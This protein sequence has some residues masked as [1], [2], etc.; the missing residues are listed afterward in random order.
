MRILN[1]WSRQPEV[2]PVAL[3]NPRRSGVRKTGAPSSQKGVRKLPP[4]GS[5][6]LIFCTRPHAHDQSFH[7]DV[8]ADPQNVGAAGVQLLWSVQLSPKSYASSYTCA[9]LA[10]WQV[11]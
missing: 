9:C 5:G 10:A 1:G 8:A 6:S 11:L 2:R 4:T 3:P 7:G